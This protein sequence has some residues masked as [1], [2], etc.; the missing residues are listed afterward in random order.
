MK[1][2]IKNMKFRKN[3]KLRKKQYEILKNSMKFRKKKI[4]KLGDHFFV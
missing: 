3:M 1:F 4:R 2:R